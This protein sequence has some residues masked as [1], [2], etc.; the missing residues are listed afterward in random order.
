MKTLKQLFSLAMVLLAAGGSLATPVQFPIRQMFG[1]GNYTRPFTVTA[2]ASSLT[3]NTNLFIGS[4]T[5]VVPT[6]G[7]NP[8][9]AL[10]PNNYVVTFSDSRTPWRI[11]VPNTTSVQSALL[12]TV[13]TLPTFSYVP[14]EPPYTNTPAPAGQISGRGIGTNLAGVQPFSTNLVDWSKLGT[15][16]VGTKY[17]NSTGLVAVIDGNGIGTNTAHLDPAGA[18]ASVSNYYRGMA[19]NGA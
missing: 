8:I 17:T 11:A 10:T 9:V 13:G 19:S 2:V 16:G 7:T 1:T 6:G 18:A 12:L 3:D 14:I 5:N 15:N 4:T